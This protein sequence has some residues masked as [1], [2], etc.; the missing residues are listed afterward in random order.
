MVLCLDVDECQLG[1]DAC[2][3]SF[4]CVNTAGSYRCLAKCGKGH[5]RNAITL[6]CEGLI[7]LQP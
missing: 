4:D 2:P 1:S 7:N 3:R 5:R 6:Q